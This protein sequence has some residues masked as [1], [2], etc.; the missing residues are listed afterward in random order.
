VLVEAGFS[1]FKDKLVA[2]PYTPSEKNWCPGL[3][4]FV[5]PT[6]TPTYKRINETSYKAAYDEYTP[7]WIEMRVHT[8]L[9][10]KY[11]QDT[12]Q[13]SGVISSSW[14]AEIIELLP[15]QRSIST[16]KEGES[17]SGGSPFTQISLHEQ[18]LVSGKQPGESKVGAE[19]GLQVLL[20]R[21]PVEVTDSG[22][23]AQESASW[24]SKQFCHGLAASRGEELTKPKG[25]RIRIQISS[26]HI[27]TR[28]NQFEAEYELEASWTDYLIG[29]GLKNEPGAKPIE[30]QVPKDVEGESVLLGHQVRSGVE[31]APNG[32]QR[33]IWTPKLRLQNASSVT[34][35][36]NPNLRCRRPGDSHNG[37]VWEG[38]F[39]VEGR[40][41]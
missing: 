23:Y 27:D 6:P 36:P 2:G 11:D 33:E 8:R 34:G 17:P 18:Q 41:S 40:F 24:M 9:R 37:V 22:S 16:V 30:I 20:Q 26:V 21:T 3:K 38:R 5:G 31:Q 12:G 1:D 13:L 39:S 4:G 28:K 7:A 29:T 15:N 35:L 25:V 19:V 14:P 32:E 10:F